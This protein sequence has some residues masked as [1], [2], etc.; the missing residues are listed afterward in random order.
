MSPIVRVQ[1]C[2]VAVHK[3]GH[4]STNL[5]FCDSELQAEQHF[6]EAEDHLLGGG[7]CGVRQGNPE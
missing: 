1:K 5:N 7:C 2:T 3:N 4:T 6:D